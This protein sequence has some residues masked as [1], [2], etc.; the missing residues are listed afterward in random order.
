[1][2][3]EQSPLD[4]KPWD[5]PPDAGRWEFAVPVLSLNGLGAFFSLALLSAPGGDRPDLFYLALVVPAPFAI[6]SLLAIWAAFGGR[7]GPWRL[8]VALVPPAVLV[9]GMLSRRLRLSEPGMWVV[10]LLLQAAVTSLVMLALRLGGGRIAR[11]DSPSEPFPRPFQFSLRLL[12]EWTCAIAVLSATLSLFPREAISEFAGHGKARLYVFLFLAVDT[13]LAV[14]ALGF[15]LTPKQRGPWFFW[16]AMAILLGMAIPVTLDAG[17]A[18]IAAGMMMIW[19]CQSAWMI[20][21][22]WPFRQAGFRLTW[23]RAA[24]PDG[25]PPG[26]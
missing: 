2:S 24:M 17:E 10:S 19:F 26:S 14:G 18:I 21:S 9:S 13:I 16:L 15:T 4:E 12:L 6:G 3:D 22:L 25:E 7:A 11:P 20:G 1:M 8:L 5:Q 23:G